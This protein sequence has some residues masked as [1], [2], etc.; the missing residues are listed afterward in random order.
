MFKIH[1]L[2]ISFLFIIAIL[3]FL[4]IVKKTS[5][6][7]SYLLNKLNNKDIYNLLVIILFFVAF[8]VRLYDFSSTP[9]GFNQ[10]EAMAAVDANALALYGTDHYGMSFPVCLTAWDY[11]QISILQPI[12]MIPFIKIL[13]LTIFAVRL[14]ILIISFISIFV[15]F[16]FTKKVFNKYMALVVL[17]FV[18]INPWHISLS[19]LALESSLFP[20]FILFSIYFLYKGILEKKVFIYISMVF[21]GFTMYSYGLAYFTVPCL[22]IL[23]CTF[24]L[25]DK[26][27]TNIQAIISV[28]VYLL[29][30]WPIYAMMFINYFKLPSINI[31]FFTIPAFP[32][33]IMVDNLLIFSDNIPKQFFYNI[34][35]MIKTFFS[36]KQNWSFVSEIG[37]LYLFTI[38]IILI[39]MFEFFKNYKFN[40][41]GK[42]ILLSLFITGFFTGCMIE[43]TNINILN[44]FFI[45]IIIFC[46]LGLYK[47]IFYTNNKY[48]AYMPL[49]FYL[50]SFCF[51]IS[52]YFTVYKD[53]LDYHFYGG[54]K[55]SVNF[56]Q[57]TNKNKL[58]ITTHTQYEGSYQ[59]SEILTLF[60]CNVDPLYFQG[61][62]VMQDLATNTFFK[63]NERYIYTNYS[64]KN[65]D[66]K[67]Y[68]GV[69][70]FNYENEGDVF[71]E[72]Y[73]EIYI[74]E[75]Y[76]VALLR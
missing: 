40:K 72:E 60:Y 47:I 24:F 18:T 46:V 10:D 51:F 56:A 23:L 17:F 61:K 67:N 43:I 27:I 13:G 68:D 16:D 58:Y 12:L 2:N 76:A 55:E 39:G 36:Q 44:I 74:F 5:L 4:T 62:T 69:Y 53:D 31:L 35:S 3:S 70:V 26:K 45:P 20:S 57:S 25:Y 64:K 33:T 8:L 32:N 63:Y 14:P 65:I 41:T 34:Y 30:S 1:L 22:L 73:Y 21:F 11:T 19:H 54:F 66:L 37:P 15:I 38:P 50:I 71:P 7:D 9:L 48:I 29:V 6:F 59:V 49:S 75:G 28:C 52:V 42:T